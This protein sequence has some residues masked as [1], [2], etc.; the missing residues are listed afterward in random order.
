MF[1]MPTDGVDKRIRLPDPM[2]MCYEVQGC[3]QKLG[4][5]TAG[6]W[7][8]IL[9]HLS[10]NVTIRGLQAGALR[11]ILPPKNGFYI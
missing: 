2:K 1:S 5:I 7:E 10:G 9:P 8:N 4:H 11:H 6:A 3:V